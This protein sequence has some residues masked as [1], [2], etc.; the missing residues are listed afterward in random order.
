MAPRAAANEAVARLREDAVRQR[1]VPRVARSEGRSV[2]V[3]ALAAR[4]ER[5]YF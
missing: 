5:P 4:G 2:G 1:A 3:D